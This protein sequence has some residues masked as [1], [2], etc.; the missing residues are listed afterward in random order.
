MN[1]REHDLLKEMVREIDAVIAG[2]ADNDEE[3]LARAVRIT[4]LEQ[5]IRGHEQ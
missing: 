2:K 5:E 1:T 3:S 4:A